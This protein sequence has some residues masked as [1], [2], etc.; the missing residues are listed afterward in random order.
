VG[1]WRDVQDALGATVANV[2]GSVRIVAKSNLGPAVTL[3]DGQ[4]ADAGPGLLEAL[5]IRASVTVYGAN[6]A[7]LYQTAPE[8]ATD[9][10]RAGAA[11]LL[12]G[13]LV[14]ILWRGLTR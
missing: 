5:G 11:L 2:A 8:P 4:A 12:A 9:P 3:Y 7:V 13:G 6:G 14:W 1:L 10:V